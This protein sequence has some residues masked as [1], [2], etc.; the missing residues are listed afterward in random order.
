MSCKNKTSKAA[1]HVLAESRVFPEA[2]RSPEA[3][4]A[5]A[6]E[7]AENDDTN[8]QITLGRG[9]NVFGDYANPLEV[10]R[11]VLDFAA[12][13]AAGLIDSF[14]VS[15]TTFEV[16]EGN[17]LS[18]FSED[19]SVNARVSGSSGPFSGAIETNFSESTF[20]RMEFAYATLQFL[21][22]TR[23]VQILETRAEN[24]RDYLTD[25]ARRDIDDPAFS[26]HQLI[27]LYGS[28]VLVNVYLGG[29]LD[30]S[31]AT[32]L[33]EITSSKS[34]G[35]AVQASYKGVIN[36][37]DLE[38]DTLTEQEL[39][40]FEERSS[41]RT[42]ARGGQSELMGNDLEPERL[43][44]WL[45][46]IA[47]NQVLVAF[48]NEQ[49]VVPIWELAAD[50]DR[51]DAIRAAFEAR[52][53]ALSGALGDG[54]VRFLVT[55]SMKVPNGKDADEGPNLEVYGTAVA[56]AMPDTTI[57]DA[58]VDEQTLFSRF[59]GNDYVIIKEN[60][61]TQIGSTLLQFAS[62]DEVRSGIE[63]LSTLLERD[64]GSSGDDPMG[65]EIARLPFREPV[66]DASGDV[67]VRPLVG[68]H[69]LTHRSGGAHVQVIYDIALVE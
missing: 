11:P 41:F 37:A 48:N 66:V 26:A 32:D 44:A 21:T 23:Q 61:E 50:P 60:Q 52:E 16:F 64:P 55:L 18:E 57:A 59:G 29:R 2:F 30:Y 65:T 38:A 69:T 7:L 13:D 25:L 63:L 10:T 47:G 8:G 58:Y 53:A 20:Q 1:T 40:S 56:K 43:D 5:R 54:P 39:R 42:V 14:N 3:Y 6:L 34:L 28:H 12:L 27:E 17:S 15:T 62:F 31:M 51:A 36:S 4:E 49:P 67:V 35:V 22:L 33:S 45:A 46:T 68:R 9:Y 24:L 19:M